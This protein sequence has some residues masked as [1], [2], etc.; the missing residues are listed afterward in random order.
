[1]RLF[2]ILRKPLGGTVAATALTYGT[3][4]INIDG[5]RVGTGAGKGWT[6]P[7][8]GVVR[9]TYNMANDGSFTAS[10]GGDPTKGRWPAN[11][12]LHQPSDEILS[13]FPNDSKS[14]GGQPK[15][16]GYLGG[17]TYGLAQRGYARPAS[18]FTM[19]PSQGPA[20]RYFYH[21]PR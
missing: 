3:A 12:I 2:Y 1:M 14:G 6:T 21:I 8:A 16:G 10:I 5:G 4:G 13:T 20:Y 19:D 7:A 11:V 18:N 15:P 17:V 9:G